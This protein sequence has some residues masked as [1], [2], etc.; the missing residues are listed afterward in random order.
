MKT[1]LI[2]L[3]T[4]TF[5]VLCN[6]KQK[7]EHWNKVV[8]LF[9]DQQCFSPIIFYWSVWR[10]CSENGVLVGQCGWECYSFEFNSYSHSNTS[11]IPSLIFNPSLSQHFPFLLKQTK[12]NINS[13]S[14]G[15]IIIIIL[16]S[17][18][19]VL[20]CCCFSTLPK[21]E[22]LVFLLFSSCVHGN[23]NEKENKNNKLER[24]R[25]SK[26]TQKKRNTYE[27]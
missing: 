17:A 4:K 26:E 25:K 21:I 19:I 9:L 24:R 22:N 20:N 8:Q 14:L 5:C 15:F 11:L 13:F 16:F 27:N 23:N 7:P 10:K 1:R 6:F 12:K 2:F 3:Q 18:K